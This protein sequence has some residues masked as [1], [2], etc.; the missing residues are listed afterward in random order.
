MRIQLKKVRVEIGS[1]PVI[2]EKD[3]I[4]FSSFEEMNKVLTP[5]RINILNKIREK[6]PESIY[7]LAQLL[8]KDQANLTKDVYLLEENGFL[9]IEKN[10]KG[11]RVSSKPNCEIDKI[12]MIIKIG[13]GAFG[14]AAEAFGSISE[15]FKG[16]RL[17]ENKKYAKEK[18]KKVLSPVRK[19]AEKIASR[20]DK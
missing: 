4:Y 20:L 11:N 14:V 1:K 5:G 6:S 13:A 15:E 17:D 8:G 7:E 9:E 12:E 19:V 2:K 16:G 10:K 3:N 18:T